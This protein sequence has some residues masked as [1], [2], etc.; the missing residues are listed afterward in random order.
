MDTC[1]APPERATDQQLAAD[2][3]FISGSPLMTTL[4]GC[5]SGLLAV[6]NQERQI[7]AVND[8]LLA[9][10]G[11]PDASQ[12]LGL[13]PGEAV[14]CIHA[15]EPPAG[16][17]TTPFCPSCGAVIAIMAA[18]ETSCPQERLCAMTARRNRQEIEL[19]FRV[20]A[21]PVEVDGRRF[22]LFFL[23]DV[24]DEQWRA[25]LERSFF[26]DLG[27]TLNALFA[28]AQ[29]LQVAAANPSGDRQQLLGLVSQI[30]RL[31]TRLSQEVAV[32]RA[33]SR[34]S[35][36]EPPVRPAP[37]EVPLA[38]LLLE[39]AADFRK[40][41]AA[42]GKQLLASLPP[43]VTI[44]TDPTLLRRILANMIV[45][46]LEASFPGQEVRLSCLVADG[47]AELSVWSQEPIPEPIQRRI[48][49][50]HFSTK[51]GAGRGLGTYAM[52]LLGERVLGGRVWFVSSPETGTRFA[53]ALP[54][55]HQSPAP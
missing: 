4:L 36:T 50:R 53:I 11:L 25:A 15:Y 21:A 7:L 52:K 37:A 33:L 3:A 10:L 28:G 8:A 16:C 35:A 29:L 23:Q 46:A 14:P 43:A 20:R 26:H 39:L 42:A 34:T 51:P 32:Q 2:I 48:F 19:C 47:E 49:Q 5:A 17:G 45:N 41:P 18:L 30:D 40:H 12:A 22:L 13:R 24:T 31:A 27:N 6:L 1:F 38:E 44:R 54:A 55:G 9:T